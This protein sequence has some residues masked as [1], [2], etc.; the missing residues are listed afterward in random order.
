[1]AGGESAGIVVAPKGGLCRK[2]NRTDNESATDGHQSKGVIQG[3]KPVSAAV[4]DRNQINRRSQAHGTG[5]KTGTV[6]SPRSK[7]DGS[8]LPRLLVGDCRRCYQLGARTQ[9]PLAE[10]NCSALIADNRQM[11]KP[12]R[13]RVQ[14]QGETRKKP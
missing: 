14:D 12:R 3:Y 13:K 2:S 6:G 1:M 9:R 8:E 4:D 5:M 7:A 11:R 10:S